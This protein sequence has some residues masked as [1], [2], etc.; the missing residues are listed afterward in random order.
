MT[1][2][3]HASTRYPACEAGKPWVSVPNPLFFTVLLRLSLELC[4][5]HVSLTTGVLIRFCQS[6]VFLGS[7]T[8][9]NRKDLLFSVLVCSFCHFCPTKGLSPAMGTGSILQLFHV[10]LGWASSH[11]LGMPLAA[12]QCLPLHPTSMG[13]SELLKH[14]R[15][16]SSALSPE[17]C[18]QLLTAPL[19]SS[20]VL[21]TPT[22]PFV[23]ATPAVVAASCSYHLC[24]PSLFSFGF[25][26]SPGSVSPSP[27]IKVSWVKY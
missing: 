16:L 12:G 25:F 3:V 9:G 21:V 22:C 27:L 20:R 24:S 2:L 6:R 23:P 4:K 13:A 1:S 15:H 5:P 17:V 11:P 8:A 10:L 14:H 18:A 19:P 7:C 26:T